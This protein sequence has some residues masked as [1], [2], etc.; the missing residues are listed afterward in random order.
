MRKTAVIL[1]AIH[2]IVA[3][4]LIAAVLPDS[5]PIHYNAAGVVDGWG[6]KWV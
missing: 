6:S 4:V 2:F 3:M 1:S 5:V